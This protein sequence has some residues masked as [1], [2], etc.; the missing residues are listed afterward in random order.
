MRVY[1]SGSEGITLQIWRER[2]F[3]SAWLPFA[4][5]LALADAIAKPRRRVG[6][7]E[8]LGVHREC[9]NHRMTIKLGDRPELWEMARHMLTRFY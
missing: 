1:R 9:G 2:E 6:H 7:N 8:L 5:A 3:M 4:D